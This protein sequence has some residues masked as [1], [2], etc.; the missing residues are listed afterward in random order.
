MKLDHLDWTDIEKQLNEQGYAKT[1]PVLSA[2][3][4]GKLVKMYENDQLFRS[5]I[6]ME[7]YRFGRGDYKYFADPLPETVQGLREGAYPPLAAIA[8]RWMKRIGSDQHYPD[9]LVD[10]LERCRKK[11][12]TKPTPLLLHYETGGYNCLHQDLYGDL[13]FPIQITSILTSS[14][15]YKG[16]EFLLIEQRPRMQSRGEAIRCEQGELIIFPVRYRP[17]QGSRGYYQVNMRHGVS[18]IQSGTRY[19]LGVIFH[20][21]K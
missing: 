4:C 14:S 12:Q 5:K 6:E 10:Y 1:P 18:R 7:R 3:D 11:G 17:A 21:A 8:N 19:S 2:Q 15:E 20:N 13:V 9:Q 16:G